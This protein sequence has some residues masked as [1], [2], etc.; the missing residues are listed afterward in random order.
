MHEIIQGY[1][2]VNGETV[3]T[4]KRAVVNA[5]ILEVEA[6]TTGLCGGDSGYGGRT[7]IRIEDMGGTDITALPVADGGFIVHLGGDAELVTMIEALE[8]VVEVLKD[9]MG[10]CR[11]EDPDDK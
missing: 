2:E 6:G 3:T 7:Y 9:E 8:F 1:R 4:Y 10:E 11:W 5:N